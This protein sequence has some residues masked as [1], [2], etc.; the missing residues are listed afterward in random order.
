MF[1]EGYTSRLKQRD[2]IGIFTIYVNGEMYYE[3]I[4]IFYAQY[5]TD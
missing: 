1:A 4:T 3:L 2:E 5:T